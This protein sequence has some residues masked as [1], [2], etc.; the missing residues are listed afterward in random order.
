M[1]TISPITVADVPG[2]DSRDLAL[3]PYGAKRA[4][5]IARHRG[6]RVEKVGRA[7]R[8]SHPTQVNDY[9]LA[10]VDGLV[11][12]AHENAWKI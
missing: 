5:G 6:W 10:T 9:L 8:F 2:A 7:Y 12:M 4:I 11:F 3:L 1:T